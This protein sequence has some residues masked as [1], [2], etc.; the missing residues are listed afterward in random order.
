MERNNPEEHS[1]A[2]KEDID[3]LKASSPFS[4]GGQQSTVWRHYALRETLRTS[5]P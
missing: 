3:V 2:E 5:R 1:A 4:F